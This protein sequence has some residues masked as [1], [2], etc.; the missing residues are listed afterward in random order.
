MYVVLSSRQ[1]HCAASVY[2]TLRARGEDV[3]LIDD[4]MPTSELSL[5]WLAGGIGD[6]RI[7]TRDRHVG[8]EDVQGILL[9]MTNPFQ[10]SADQSKEDSRYVLMEVAAAIEGVLNAFD[11]PVV[12]RPVP[13]CSGRLV[14]ARRGGAHLVA[15]AGFRVPDMFITSD[16]DQIGTLAKGSDCETFRIS[17]LHAPIPPRF[18]SAG[19]LE[20]WVQE[21]C[22]CGGA[23]P[24]WI[25]GVPS[26]EHRRM[27]VAGDATVCVEAPATDV[28][29]R[30]LTSCPG[31]VRKQ[32][33]SLV[34]GL[35][36]TFACIDLVL[37]SD[38]EAHC[39]EVH[40]FPIYNDCD[41]EA[42]T[43]I[44]SALVDALTADAGVGA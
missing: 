16:S 7:G 43:A 4:A 3:L 15:D 23:L 44:T 37:E 27:F 11:G 36:L 14:Y 1:D 12:N 6:D 28:R 35:D 40:E 19:D 21:T 25:Q 10:S 2:Q 5:N 8:F 39:L 29:R 41:D 33:Q 30:R 26:G 13:G 38:G 32:A 22:V 18:V 20:K 9:R 34:A 31:K 24:V 42:Q 17:G